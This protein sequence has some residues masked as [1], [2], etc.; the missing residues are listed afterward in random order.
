MLI[1]GLGT[2]LL[3]H[4]WSWWEYK[5]VQP[6]KA[7]WQYLLA[8]SILYN[9]PFRNTCVEEV[10]H[11]CVCNREETSSQGVSGAAVLLEDLGPTHTAFR[12]WSCSPEVPILL[13]TVNGGLFWFLKGT[14]RPL[15]CGPLPT[16][17]RDSSRPAGESCVVYSRE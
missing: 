8:K 10:V 17:P 4:G 6:W 1:K 13:W 16:W 9:I 5:L 3:E 15:P 11:C 7:I 12:S 2:R 14:H